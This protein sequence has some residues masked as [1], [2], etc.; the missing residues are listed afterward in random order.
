[1][2]LIKWSSDLSVNVVEIDRQHQALVGMINE[3]NDA[4]SDKKATDV[5]GKIIDN[6]INYA[7]NHFAQE[8]R[9]FD[10][11]KYPDTARHKAEHREFVKKVNDFHESFKKGKLFLSVGVMNF[12][13]DWLVNHIKGTDKKYSRFFNEHGLK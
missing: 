6:L 3:L 13:R 5:L 4:M 1:M 10:Q 7:A 12:L 8:E 2:S 11:F 9:Y